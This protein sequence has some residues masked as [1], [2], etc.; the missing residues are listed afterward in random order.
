MKIVRKFA[1]TSKNTFSIGPVKKLIK[2]YQ[3]HQLVSID[4]F[5]NTSRI[6]KIT[7][8]LDPDMPTDYH[9]D[10]LDFLKMFETNSVDLVLY[11]P[12]FTPRQ[13]ADCYKKFDRTVNKETTQISYWWNQKRE[14]SRI[15]KPGGIV[16]GCGY[17]SNGCGKKY[18]FSL[19]EVLLVAHGS[20][21]NDTIV[22]VDQKLQSKIC[23]LVKNDT[24]SI[25]T[26]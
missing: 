9:M 17:N 21:H 8:D 13:V 16:I 6:A 19:K 18:G 1:P 14:L 22:T 10:A 23:E 26:V 24:K 11:D 20:N 7:N 4:P 25:K 12:P 5:A 3:N 2:R 15:V